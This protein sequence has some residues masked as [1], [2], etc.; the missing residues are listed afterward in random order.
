MRFRGR[1]EPIDFA[2]NRKKAK[3]Q[4]DKWLAGPILTTTSENVFYSVQKSG[5]KHLKLWTLAELCDPC[6]IGI[7]ELND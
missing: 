3:W 5:M 2:V 1:E 6:N 4:I 7:L